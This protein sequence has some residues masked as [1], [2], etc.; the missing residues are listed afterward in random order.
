MTRLLTKPENDDD[1]TDVDLLAGNSE[2]ISSIVDDI[3][4]QLSSITSE[5]GADKLDVRFTVKVYRVVENKAEL[6]W[7]FDCTPAELPILQKL[8][9]E[10]DG[11]RFE[12]RVY[13]NNRI[14]KRVKVVVES[15]KKPVAAQL[16][17]ND[18]AEM[19]KEMGRQQQEN[20]NMLKDTVLQMV[21]KPSTPPPSQIETMTLMMEL[22]KSMKDFA[23]PQIPQAPAFDPEKMFD[24]FLKGMEMGRDSG[25][26]GE[27]GLMDIAKELIK[28]PLLGSLAQAV[29]NPPQ[30]PRPPAGMSIPIQQKPLAQ[31]I[32][33]NTANQQERNPDFKPQPPTQGEN[34]TNPVIKHYL[35]MLIQKAENDSDPVL[36]AEFILDNAPQSMVEENIMREDLIEYASSI[37]PRVKQHE[38]W[39]TE[40]R[41]HIVSV[42][43]LPDETEEDEGD[44]DNPGELTLDATV[45]PDNASNDTVRPL[46]NAT[47]T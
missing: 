36:Y 5:L 34:M 32:P 3:D 39:F 35:N 42:L 43:T 1:I 8:R 27:T 19:L 26:G 10:Y 45:T 46:G 20:F 41:D 44:R 7:L 16:V 22:M 38:K 4:A 11:G 17:K 37:D 13:K 31:K 23:S 33:L 6:A 25:G 12:C 24:L 40:L 28:S 2:D 30:L 18:M 9:D 21:G 14:Y 29:N 15:P 47:N